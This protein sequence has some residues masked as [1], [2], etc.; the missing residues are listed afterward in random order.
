[1]TRSHLRGYRRPQCG[2]T[3]YAATKAG[4]IGYV[5]ALSRLLAARGISV[6]AVAPGPIETPMMQAIP[7]FFRELGRRFSSLSQ[8]GI[9]RD[10]AE[11]ITFLATPAAAR[12]TGQTIRICGQNLIGA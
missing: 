4:V 7:F 6:N 3:N 10:V 9:P 12:I 1:M 5:G 11:L 8:A 2:Q